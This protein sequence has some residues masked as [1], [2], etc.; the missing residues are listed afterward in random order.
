[1]HGSHVK[2]AVEQLTTERWSLFKV[3]L[4]CERVVR[5]VLEDHRTPGDTLPRRPY[6]DSTPKMGQIP[7]FSSG[8][9]VVLVVCCL[10]LTLGEFW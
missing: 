5:R 3:S 10:R 1:M 2:E 6:V 8:S 7:G 9:A 4:V